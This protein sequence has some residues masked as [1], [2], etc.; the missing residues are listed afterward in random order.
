ML[1]KPLFDVHQSYC[2]VAMKQYDKRDKRE[3]YDRR[4]HYHDCR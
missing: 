3:I 1:L 4:R 2:F